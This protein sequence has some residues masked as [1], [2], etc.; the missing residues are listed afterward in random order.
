MVSLCVCVWEA[1]PVSALSK[2]HP[3]ASSPAGS[4]LWLEDASP[5][6]NIWTP[7]DEEAGLA[8]TLLEVDWE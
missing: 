4:Q 8:L 3:Q 6:P 7:N 1:A 5:G 2:S